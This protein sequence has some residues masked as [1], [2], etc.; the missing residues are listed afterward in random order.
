[1]HFTCHPQYF[2]VSSEHFE[3]FLVLKVWWQSLKCKIRT[4]EQ[5]KRWINLNTLIIV[6]KCSHWN[7]PCSMHFWKHTS[8][9][10]IQ[11]YHNCKKWHGCPN[12]VRIFFHEFSRFSR[13]NFQNFPDIFTHRILELRC[14]LW[15]FLFEKA[16]FQ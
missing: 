3:D 10:T 7:R 1:M 5:R 13:Q 15:K 9:W 6:A 2:H 14:T 4:L 8:Y 11:L 16:L 12:L